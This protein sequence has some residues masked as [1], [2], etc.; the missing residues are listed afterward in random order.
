MAAKLMTRIPKVEASVTTLVAP[1]IKKTLGWF[2]FRARG[3]RV[4]NQTSLVSK[5]LKPEYLSR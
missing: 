5:E 2:S 4:A 3:T 1:R